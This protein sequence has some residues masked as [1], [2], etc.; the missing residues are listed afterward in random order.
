MDRKLFLKRGLIGLGTVIA[1]PT[2][3]NA[4]SKDDDDDS[5]ENTE[6]ECTVSPS[7][8]NGPYPIISPSSY[9]RSDIRGDRTGVTMTFT[10]TVLDKSDGCTPLSGVLVDVWMCDKDGNYSQY[11]SYTSSNWQRGRQ[12]TDSD[13]VVTFTA[14]FP[15][16]YSGRAPHIHI[17]ILTSGGNSLLVSQ[18]AF[19]VDVYT[20]VYASTGYNGAPDTSNSQDSVFSDSLSE[21]M[22]DSATGSVSAGYTVLKTITV[23]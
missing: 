23:S 4:C 3:L 10:V 2:V 19:P 22:A 15:G 9:V 5:S 17:E 14:I 21:N 11:G 20:T 12:T 1:L 16:W 8:T 13:G 6:G 7:E 18:V